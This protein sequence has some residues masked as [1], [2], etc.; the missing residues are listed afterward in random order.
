MG[1][2][3]IFSL[4]SEKVSFEVFDFLSQILLQENLTIFYR[5]IVVESS[6]CQLEDFGLRTNKS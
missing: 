3:F 5:L 4:F 6:Y 2:S 1:S